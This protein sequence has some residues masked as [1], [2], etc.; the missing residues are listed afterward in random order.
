MCS[1]HCPG[2]G[3][4]TGSVSLIRIPVRATDVLPSTSLVVSY[5]PRPSIHLP[6][7]RLGRLL[8]WLRYDLLLRGRSFPM[9]RRGPRLARTEGFCCLRALDMLDVIF[10]RSIASDPWP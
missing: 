4:R 9:E 2:G 3:P 1:L 10:S 7:T 5:S 8:L 6:A